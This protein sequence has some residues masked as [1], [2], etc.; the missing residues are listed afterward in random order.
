MLCGWQQ[1]GPHGT[2]SCHLSPV[3]SSREHTSRSDL[4][5]LWFSCC[6]VKQAGAENAPFPLLI[7]KGSCPEA[8]GGPQHLLLDRLIH[9]YLLDHQGLLMLCS[10]WEGL[11]PGETGTANLKSP[12][13][14]AAE[15]KLEHSESL[16]P[17]RGSQP[18]PWGFLNTK[19]SHWWVIGYDWTQGRGRN[20]SVNSND[21]WK[22]DTEWRDAVPEL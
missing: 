14:L 18:I 19:A 15:P 20:R 8:D 6:A 16:G 2:V 9:C 21:F 7:K 1:K 22:R 12:S 13:W 4:V 3:F 17:R 10:Y 11:K 5:Q